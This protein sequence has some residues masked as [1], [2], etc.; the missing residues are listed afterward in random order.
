MTIN[1]RIEFPVMPLYASC[2]DMVRDKKK[3]GAIDEEGGRGGDE[4]QG[5]IKGK[6]TREDTAALSLFCNAPKVLR[7]IYEYQNCISTIV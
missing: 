4:E 3:E 7:S 5:Q 2:E 6:S 1:R